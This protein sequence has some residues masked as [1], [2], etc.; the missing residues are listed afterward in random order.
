MKEKTIIKSMINITAFPKS[1][2]VYIFKSNDEIIYIGSSKNLYQR[3]SVHNTE[4][5]KGS[6]ARQN[7]PL[8]KF[9]SKSP[10]T[11][12]FQLTDNYRE[13]EQKLIEKYHPIYNAIRAFTGLGARKG[14]KAEYAKEYNKKYKEEIRQYQ[15]QYNNKYYDSH[16][17]EILE[18]MKQY[19]DSH[20]EE[21][22]QYQKQQCLYNGEI[23]TLC[24]LSMRFKRQGIPHPTIEAKKYLIG[25]K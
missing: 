23:M 20:R 18:E 12:E 4:I 21:I 19:N 15:K 24:A 11:V 16:R 7:Q 14:R 10:F 3:M 1:S 5:R 6:N 2:G 8:Y 17:E 25:D 9:L 13:E 22:K